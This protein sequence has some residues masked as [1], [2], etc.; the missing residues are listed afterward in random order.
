MPERW[1][2]FPLC[3]MASTE[4]R[5]RQRRLS[6]KGQG[7]VGVGLSPC[8]LEEPPAESLLCFK[9]SAAELASELGLS[10]H[11]LVGFSCPFVAFCFIGSGL[12]ALG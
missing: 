8:A 9:T 7:S 6:L 3:L 12:K 2:F 10:R 1:I 11:R 4:G 5:K